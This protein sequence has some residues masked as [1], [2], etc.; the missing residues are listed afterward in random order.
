MQDAGQIGW[1]LSLM[2]SMC[3]ALRLARF[4]TNLD[5]PPPPWTRNF[6]TGVPA[7]AGGGLALI[8][9]ALTFQFGDGFFRQPAFAG[10]LMFVIALL[11]VSRLPTFSGKR[12]RVEQRWILPLMLLVGLL[13]AAMVSAPW[14]TLWLVALA[15]I[16]SFPFSVRSFKRLKKEAERVAGSND[17]GEPAA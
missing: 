6:F 5:A 15:Y 8:P 1:M 4:N 7:P 14:M 2:F 9:M 11:M 17:G 16:S 13:A 3:C 12:I 10:T